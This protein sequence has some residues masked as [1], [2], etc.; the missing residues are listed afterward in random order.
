MI[1]KHSVSG[2]A[3]VYQEAEIITCKTFTTDFLDAFREGGER[4]EK[5]DKTAGTQ[6]ECQQRHLEFCSEM[7]DAVE[8][9]IR[10][11]MYFSVGEISIRTCI[12]DMLKW[13][14]I[15]VLVLYT[16]G[17][18][19][20]CIVLGSSKDTPPQ[21]VYILNDDGKTVERL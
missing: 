4:R 15:T 19:E 12:T 11:E 6:E 7:H 21:Q 8:A 18:P 13:G 1:L 17:K 14:A 2:G 20:S 9:H 3:W 5:L 10:R 16:Q